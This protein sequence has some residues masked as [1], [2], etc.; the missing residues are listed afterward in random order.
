MVS[1]APPWAPEGQAHRVQG[2]CLT[3]TAACDGGTL[4]TRRRRTGRRLATHLA[5]RALQTHRTEPIVAA[6]GKRI[7]FGLRG[8]GHQSLGPTRAAAR[9]QES[10][11]PHHGRG[12]AAALS[13]GPER[14]AACDARLVKGCSSESL[15][16]SAGA[17][18][19]QRKV[20]RKRKK[21]R[22]KNKGVP[23]GQS[24]WDHGGGTTF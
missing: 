6:V 4:P 9:G 13:V 19:R 7:A 14:P 8:R 16:D 1:L 3:V 18:P 23:G 10:L 21:Q 17:K 24:V 5:L 11:G 15:S 12:S 20:R 2:P 22:N